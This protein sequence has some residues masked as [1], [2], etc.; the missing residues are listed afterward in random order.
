[1]SVTLERGVDIIQRKKER[2]VTERTVSEIDKMNEYDVE[3][4]SDILDLTCELSS[5]DDDIAC[6]LEQAEKIL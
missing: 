4:D 6:T 3:L 1:M 2:L 5:M